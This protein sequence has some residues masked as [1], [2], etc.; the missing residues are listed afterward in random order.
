MTFDGFGG[1]V[2]HH[3]VVSEFGYLLRY[4]TDGKLEES[5][6]R[7][8]FLQ[9]LFREYDK[10]AKNRNASITM[11]YKSEGCILG[12]GFYSTG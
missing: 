4:L 2:I 7:S 11:A 5:G 12:R 9:W 6:F 10:L 8:L 1:L 3:L